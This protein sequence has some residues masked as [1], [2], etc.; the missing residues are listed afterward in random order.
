VDETLRRV[1]VD[2]DSLAASGVFPPVADDCKFCDFTG[3]CGPF[4][5]DRARRKADDPRLAAFKRLREI[6]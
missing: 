3:V 2:L 6:P 1:L 5:E 4:R